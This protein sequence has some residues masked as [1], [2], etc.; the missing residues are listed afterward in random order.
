MST[1]VREGQGDKMRGLDST[2]YL[3]CSLHDSLKVTVPRAKRIYC[4]LWATVTVLPNSTYSRYRHYYYIILIYLFCCFAPDLF[5]KAWS[6]YNINTIWAASQEKVPSGMT[7][8]QQRFRPG[9][10]ST[11]WSVSSLSAWRVL[12]DLLSIHPSRWAWASEFRQVA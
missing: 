3:P 5:C 1:G 12:L 4:W 6:A 11:Q 8:T 9:C 2:F 10:T 7:N